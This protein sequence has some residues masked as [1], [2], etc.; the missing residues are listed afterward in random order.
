MGNLINRLTKNNMS[1]L[2]AESLYQQLV[3]TFEESETFQT[4]S[5]LST[6]RH[7]A[8]ERFQKEGFPTVKNEEWKYTNLH[9]LVNKPYVLNIQADVDKVDASLADIPNLDAH[10]IVLVNGQFVLA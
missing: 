10:R 4:S 9:S 8:F 3:S 1:T 6:I 7:E 2:V 5:K